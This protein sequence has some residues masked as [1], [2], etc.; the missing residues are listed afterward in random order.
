[1]CMCVL[2]CVRVCVCVCVRARARVCM[3]VLACVRVCMCVHVC[4][5][6]CVGGSVVTYSFLMQFYDIFLYDQA[7]QQSHFLSN[8]L[9][10]CNNVLAIMHGLVQT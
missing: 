2:A 1:M 9:I 5:R 6:A 4:G 8:N 7:H 10:H 3:C